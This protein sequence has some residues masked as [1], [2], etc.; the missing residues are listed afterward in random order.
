[1]IIKDFQFT[2]H[3]LQRA[4]DMRLDG[5]EIRECLLTPWWKQK[6]GRGDDRELFY[7]RRIT[8]VVQQDNLVVTVVWRTAQDWK[9][10]IDA[11]GIYER[12]FNEEEWA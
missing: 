1:M 3:A 10:D 6:S 4:L 2:P 12:R 9:A 5:D 7:G 11:G 8:C